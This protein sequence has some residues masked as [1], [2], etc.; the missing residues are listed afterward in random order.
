MYLDGY[1]KMAMIFDGQGSDQMNWFSPG[2]LISSPWTD[3]PGGI[4]FDSG[5]E[6]IHFS[7]E[8][9]ERIRIFYINYS[10]GGCYPSGR[11]MVTT[12][13]C[14]WEKPIRTGS[15]KFLYSALKTRATWGREGQMGDADVMAVFIK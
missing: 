5:A 3:L 10:H 14:P 2:R 6:G 1:E 9:Y 8:G 11:T 7:I 13:T 15:S 12:N 4:Q